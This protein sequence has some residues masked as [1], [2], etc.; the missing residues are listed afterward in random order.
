MLRFRFFKSRG[1]TLIELLVVIAI[2]AILIGLLLPAVQKVREAA[3]RT[4]CKNN[5]KQIG[6]AVHNYESVKG[7][8]PQASWPYYIRPYIE[9]NNNYGGS[10]M[11]IFLCPSRHTGR[12]LTLDYTG[13]SQFNSFLYAQKIL[14]ITDGTSNTMMLAEKAGT[15][16]AGAG[17]PSLPSGVWYYSYPGGGGGYVPTYDN[18]QSPVNDT[19][20]QDAA[21]TGGTATTI[22]VY[23]YYDPAQNWGWNYKENFSTSPYYDIEYDDAAM[24]KPYFYDTW[25]YTPSYWEVVV[26][27]FSYP[28]VSVSVPVT[29]SAGVSG[30]GSRHPT[31]MNILMCDGAVRTYPYGL[32][33]LGAVIG[34]DDGQPIPNF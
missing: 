31:G 4:K 2:I 3:A 25:G 21:P 27:N 7:T 13:G 11:S 10:P 28:P 18:G 34:R 32:T 5:L 9:Q 16:G 14:D 24:T 17:A 23:S 22:T 6:L 15:L 20:Q 12:E 1:F 26:E 30:F 29:P 8:L 33:S 19:A